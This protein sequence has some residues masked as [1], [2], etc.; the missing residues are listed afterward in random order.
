MFENAE[1]NVRMKGK[2]QE[3]LQQKASSRG[4][5]EGRMDCL[6]N[7]KSPRR[8]RERMQK[9][10]AG[11]EATLELLQTSLSGRAPCEDIHFLSRGSSPS[12]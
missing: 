2:E 12:A 9:T 6:Q 7:K 5:V 10:A 8:P 3:T 11:G 1:L 4:N